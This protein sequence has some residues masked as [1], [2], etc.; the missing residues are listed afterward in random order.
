[1]FGVFFDSDLYSDVK[2]LLVDYERQISC[3]R[4]VLA[5]SDFFR[6]ALSG[7]FIESSA[8]SLHFR[9]FGFLAL[10]IE[11]LYTNTFDLKLGDGHALVGSLIAAQQLQILPLEAA[12]KRH[13]K[14]VDTKLALHSLF[15]NVPNCCPDAGH[16]VVGAIAATVAHDLYEVVEDPVQRAML[17]G[18]CYTSFVAVVAQPQ[19]SIFRENDLWHLIKEYLGTNDL[20]PEE[21]RA[22][23]DTIV[24]QDLSADALQEVSKHDIIKSEIL[25]LAA[26]TRLKSYESGGGP[27]HRTRK[28]CKSCLLLEPPPQ[29]N[30]ADFGR[31]GFRGGIFDYIRG[32]DRNGQ[33]TINPVQRGVVLKSGTLGSCHMKLHH[34]LGHHG[35]RLWTAND[36]TQA[37]YTIDLGV[38][39]RAWVSAYALR[40]GG[41]ISRA[42]NWVLEGWDLALQE[43]VVLREHQND[44]SLEPREEDEDDSDD[45]NGDNDE[46]YTND[47]AHGCHLWRSG[48]TEA[49]SRSFRSFRLRMTTAAH[50]GDYFFPISG[51][52]LYGK[53]VEVEAE[54]EDAE[55]E[56]KGAPLGFKRLIL[57]NH[58]RKRKR[59]V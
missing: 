15:D 44:C 34:V 55:E 17:L 53:L 24:L 30:M 11:S 29:Q 38:N 39:R 2:V 35:V 6:A 12:L 51:I 28:T 45:D 21:K 25:I 16:E 3:H 52:E 22:L 20:S 54:D 40:R 32:G 41:G 50:D 33:A 48:F 13:M 5:R 31:C 10:A 59:A 19:L 26:T 18:L 37:W 56:I 7:H 4:V 49:A 9:D 58:A 43:Y 14:T 23:L 42:R 57:E 36:P 27:A 47:H 8:I 1:M 46:H